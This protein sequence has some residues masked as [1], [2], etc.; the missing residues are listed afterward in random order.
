MSAAKVI[1]AHQEPMDRSDPGVAAMRLVGAA[2]GAE[3]ITCGV[4]TF[5]PGAAIPLH[6]HPC[7]ETVVV[8]EGTATAVVDGNQYELG[9]FDTTFVPAR[10]A[11]CFM[12]RTNEKM[13]FA[14]FYPD[15]NV[16][17]DPVDGNG[18]GKKQIR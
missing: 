11:H 16:S 3:N 4:A 12:N 7:E 10:I 8:L 6:T 15:I 1:Y 18:P 14:Y 2:K 17:R 9:K 13:V 5:E